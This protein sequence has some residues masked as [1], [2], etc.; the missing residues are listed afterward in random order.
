MNSVSRIYMV[1]HIFVTNPISRMMSEVPRDNEMQHVDSD[2][3]A[4]MMVQIYREHRWV[5]AGNR[6]FRGV[7]TVIEWSLWQEHGHRS[8]WCALQA[9]LGSRVIVATWLV[10][11]DGVSAEPPWGLL[12]YPPGLTYLVGLIR[13]AYILFS[14]PFSHAPKHLGSSFMLGFSLLKSTSCFWHDCTQ[15]NIIVRRWTVAKGK[16]TNV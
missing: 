9:D 14:F 4:W 16:K 8:W 6:A 13:D 1:I 15:M 5:E 11:R 3:V 12:W 10:C 7:R 2:T